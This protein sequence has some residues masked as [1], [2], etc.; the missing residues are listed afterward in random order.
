[1]GL[2]IQECCDA[3]LRAP[4]EIADAL[5]ALPPTMTGEAGWL[6]A[7]FH[8]TQ[9]RLTTFLASGQASQLVSAQAYLL[10]RGV[11]F[12]LDADVQDPDLLASAFHAAR[13]GVPV[14]LVGE[15]VSPSPWLLA[16]SDLMVS[17]SCLVGL[18]EMVC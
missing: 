8:H 6:E 16:Y 15:R 17:P 2:T 11:A 14:W 7:A 12:L 1:M 18:L 9:R 10:V 13:C 3:V 4:R 5:P